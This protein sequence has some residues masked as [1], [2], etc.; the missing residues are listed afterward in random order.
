MKRN[1]PKLPLTSE[2]RSVF[3]KQKIKLS[4]IASFQTRDLAFM[5]GCTEERAKYLIALSQFQTIPSVGPD[6]A[7]HVIDLGYYSLAE[8]KG[9]EP[10]KL[11]D[12]LEQLYGYRLD[13]CVEDGIW[14]IVHN[15]ETFTV[16]SGGGILQKKESCTAINTDIRTRGQSDD[17]TQEDVK[18][19][20]IGANLCY[21]CNNY[22]IIDPNCLGG[23]CN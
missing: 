9:R 1:A 4:A 16:K 12:Q 13:P 2:E 18:Q 11:F 20:F 6:L 23:C 8:L 19:V 10:A 21:T 3:R 7:K 17:E 14:L 15:V 5:L 22:L